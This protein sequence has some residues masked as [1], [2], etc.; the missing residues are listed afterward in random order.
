[1]NL[2]QRHSF[3]EAPDLLETV[4]ELEELGLDLNL[5]LLHE[6]LD[7]LVE[8]GGVELELA[9]HTLGFAHMHFSFLP[10]VGFSFLDV[11]GNLLN[12]NELQSFN[13]GFEVLRLLLEVVDHL[14][15]GQQL[16]FQASHCGGIDWSLCASVALG[17]GSELRVG[18]S[19]V[20]TAWPGL[21][22]LPYLRNEDGLL[23]EV[24]CRFRED[25][26]RL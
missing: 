17:I 22:T 19:A 14:V 1:M 12:L 11:V 26:T 9:Y 24:T 18:R 6:Q 23:T 5:L 3:L 2:G 21:G 4:L 10:Q 8:V 15:R 16:L 25:F 20:K 7:L 13:V